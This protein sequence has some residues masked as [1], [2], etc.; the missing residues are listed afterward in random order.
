MN[1]ENLT[2]ITGELT[3]DQWL[4]ILRSLLTDIPEKE[5]NEF[6]HDLIYNG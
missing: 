2:P 5:W 6:A 4:L 3:Q 1:D